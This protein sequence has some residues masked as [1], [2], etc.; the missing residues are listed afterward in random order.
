MN[1]DEVFALYLHFISSKVKQD[2]YSQIL[3]FILH[4]WDCVNTYG[5]EKKASNI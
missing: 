5:W 3:G 1:V 4:F 2:F